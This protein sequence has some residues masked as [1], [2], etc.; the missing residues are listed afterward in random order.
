MAEKIPNKTLSDG[1]EVDDE[2][3]MKL[4][5]KRLEDLEVV[6]EKM[7]ENIVSLQAEVASLKESSNRKAKKASFISYLNRFD[8]WWKPDKSGFN[9]K[10]P[11]TA[12]K[13]ITSE[14]QV[15]KPIISSDWHINIQQIVTASFSLEEL[16]DKRIEWRGSFYDEH[17]FLLLGDNCKV[18]GFINSF[19][20]Y[21]KY[22]TLNEARKA[23]PLCYTPF[24]LSDINGIDHTIAWESDGQVSNQQV[25][26]HEF[27]LK[28]QLVRLIDCGGYGYEY[29][30]DCESDMTIGD[31]K[32]LSDIIGFVKSFKKLDTIVFV[33][34]S[35]AIKLPAN[36]QICFNELLDNFENN[37]VENLHFVI[38]DKVDKSSLESV[39]MSVKKIHTEIADWRGKQLWQYH[40]CKLYF[41]NNFGFKY[42]MAKRLR[43]K[44]NDG[45]KWNAS[46]SWKR[47]VEQCD[48]FK[49]SCKGFISVYE[50]STFDVANFSLILRVILPEILETIQFNIEQLNLHLQPSDSIAG[51]FQQI[52]IKQKEITRSQAVCRSANC[53]K[54][55]CVV[56]FKV[57]SQSRCYNCNCEG[58]KHK[59]IPYVMTKCMSTFNNYQEFIEEFNKKNQLKFPS[60]NEYLSQI[61]EE[62]DI[63]TKK[64]NELPTADENNRFV[65]QNIRSKLFRL[66]INGL[67]IDKYCNY[68]FF[69][70]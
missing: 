45:A 24:R 25:M 26:C 61:I 33:L 49:E 4:L 52:E 68:K 1:A 3:E 5:Q 64:L 50:T 28:N 60:A 35:T 36:F 62:K 16:S 41:I 6:M 21:I 32:M 39:K 10:Q 57:K 15:K 17:N 40:K 56:H 43:L 37:A 67:T 2:D 69:D 48:R 18:K 51:N 9:G 42:I 13:N 55:L 65:I 11:I 47:S 63:I 30:S 70:D 19:D 53:Q 54:V 58:V 27:L 20:F 34:K 14:H 8:S 44:L 46:W 38:T 31:K 12:S 23:E 22:P 7:N 59:C 66:P 29:N